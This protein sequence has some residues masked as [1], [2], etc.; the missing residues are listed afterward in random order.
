MGDTR[1]PS[2]HDG[3]IVQDSATMGGSCPFR[4]LPE[5]AEDSRSGTKDVK[6]NVVV[7]IHERIIMRDCRR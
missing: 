6:Q 4:R 7:R 2:G 1:R 5:D 3:E